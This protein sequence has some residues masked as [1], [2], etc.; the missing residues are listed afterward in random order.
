MIYRALR[1]STDYV[2]TATSYADALALRAQLH[3]NQAAFAPKEGK[4]NVRIRPRLGENNPYA[5][6]YAS[7]RGQTKRGSL[8]RWSS[9]DIKREHGTRFDVYAYPRQR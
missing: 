4:I 7:G 8:H 1:N 6:L 5:H 2:G 9:Q 3:K